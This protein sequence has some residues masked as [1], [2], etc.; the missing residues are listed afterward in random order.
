MGR[1]SVEHDDIAGPESRGEHLLDVDPEGF[2]IHRPI[3]QPG[4]AEP[5]KAQASDKGH[6]LPVMGWTP[7]DGIDVPRWC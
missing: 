1:E 4:R 2:A 6:G 7:P 3:E 5:G